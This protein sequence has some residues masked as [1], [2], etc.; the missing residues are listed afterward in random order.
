MATPILAID[1]VRVGTQRLQH[2]AESLTELFGFPPLS[3]GNSHGQASFLFHTA[4]VVVYLQASETTGLQTLCFSVDNLARM[5][6]RLQRL[7][8]ELS[9]ETCADPLAQLGES[10]E[11]ITVKPDSV[12]GLGLA[13]AA[14]RNNL[15]VTRQIT[16]PAQ[17]SGLDHIVVRSGDA[18]GSA[19]LLGAQLGLD[20]RMD[21]SNPDW[22][23][24]LMFFRCGD[25]IVE[26]FQSLD[27]SD[28]TSTD[29]LYGLSWRVGDTDA[30]WTRLAEA[31]RNLSEVRKGRKPGTRVFTSRE[32]NAEVPTLLIGPA[33]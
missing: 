16:D 28:R 15:S 4:N 33:A 21:R 20:M 2:D 32:G 13:F 11:I 25:L 17:V 22:G 7:G 10:T 26:V 23:A 6:R 27:E 1:H 12:R 3:V 14:P 8:I 31:G 19:F 18:Q 29:Y 30:A 5:K 9:E 24:R